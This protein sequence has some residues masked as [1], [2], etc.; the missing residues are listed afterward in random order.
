MASLKVEGLRARRGSFTVFVER[1]EVNSIV[2]VVGRNGSG[3]TTLLDAVAGFIKAEGRVEVCGEDVS[4]LPP[5]RRRLAYVQSVPVDPPM[6]V[7]KFLMYVARRHG[8]VGEVHNVAE[9]L[10]IKDLLK[11][12]EGLSTGQKQLVNLAAALLARP[13]AFLMDEP[14]SHLDWVNKKAFDEVL[15]RLGVPI[16]F[17]T[18]DPVE[19]LYVADKL[20]VMEEGRLRCLADKPPLDVSRLVGEV[21]NL[22]RLN[23]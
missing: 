5:E 12:S 17:V 2:A 22:L 10:G 16:L 11:R 9:V 20:C 3:K 1:L 15:K 19:A 18:H 6:R 21:Q 4:A 7:D 14:T 13:C 23:R 8:T